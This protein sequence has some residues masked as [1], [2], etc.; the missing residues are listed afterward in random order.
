M[1]KKM[2]TALATGLAFMAMSGLAQADLTTIGTATY[3]GAERNLIWDDDNNGNS[4]IW[5]D[6]SNTA[7]NWT[8]QNDVWAAG[9]N[10]V[11][12]L[13]YNIESTYTV[14]WGSNSWR[15]PSAGSSPSAGYNITSSEM[16]D[17]FYNELDMLS[18]PDKGNNTTTSAEL[19]ATNFDNL[20]ASWYWSGTEYANNP[21][22]AWYFNLYFG[23]QNHR[24]KINNSYGLA[25]RSGDVSH[26]P[27][28]EP[29]T[30]LLFGSGLAG[31]AGYRRRRANR[32]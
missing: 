31:L 17:L 9:L 29:A 11:D 1:K 30:M 26:E 6:Y 3:A 13:T 16:G 14:D 18:Y 19:N 23:N 25:V 2:L 28:P 22:R 20:I 32:S 5:L 27:V 24:N 15:L 8:A 21:D 4:V 12:V 10:G 7:T